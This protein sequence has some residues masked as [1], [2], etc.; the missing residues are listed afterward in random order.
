MKEI[1]NFQLEIFNLSKINPLVTRYKVYIAYPDEPAN[2]YIFSKEVLLSLSNTVLGCPVVAGFMNNEDGSLLGGHEL[3]LALDQNNK[4]KRTPTT[5]PVG[6]ASYDQPCW[7]E[8]YKGKNFLTTFIYIWDGR[9]P[10]L[11]NLSERTIFQSMEVAVD[12][13]FDGKYKIVKEAYAL[14]L[15]LLENV[16][17][18]FEFSTITKF[19][20][21]DIGS[22]INL[23][24]SEF[25]QLKQEYENFSKPNN[26]PNLNTNFSVDSD[27]LG[28]SNFIKIDNSKDSSTDG[29]WSAPGATQLDKL[30]E[31]SNHTSLIKEAYLIVDGNDSDN[32]SINDVHYLHHVIKDNALVLHVSGVQAAFSRAKQQGLT[33]EPIDHIKRHYEE[34]GLNMDNFSEFNLTLEDYKYIFSDT[35]NNQEKEVNEEVIKEALEKFSLTAR[36]IDEILSNALSEYKYK[37]G[38]EEYRKYWVRTYDDELVYVCDYEDDKTYSFK[39]TIVDNIA[40]IDMESK[41]EVIDGGFISVNKKEIVVEEMAKEE[42]CSE[43]LPTEEMSSNEY[44]DNPAIQALNDKSAED[45]K[46]LADENLENP[47]EVN[48]SE[49]EEKSEDKDTVIM[50]LKQEIS[51]LQEKFSKME[52]NMNVCLEE[53]DKLKKFKIDIDKQNK[54]FSVETTLKEVQNILPTEEMEACRL[55][56]ENF[57]LENIDIWKNEVK[58]KAFNFSKGIPEKKPFIQVAFPNSNKPK[59]GKGLWD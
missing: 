55:S 25:N 22:K 12:E 59:G 40:T 39:Y 4:V 2:G 30:L 46:E 9:F 13:E 42:I 10:E 49:S 58:A 53:N 11:E 57:S 37:Y 3:D 45:N 34:L 44:V 38:E 33:G 8:E 23:L 27:K 48:A 18:A 28:E 50:S 1:V 14:G 19:S 17:P 56:A 32:L 16:N 51:E 47:E 29:E 36:Q 41:D 52:T 24:T 20:L 26:N 35:N 31:A 43:E 15:C 7:F 54:E 6:F 21:D 5:I